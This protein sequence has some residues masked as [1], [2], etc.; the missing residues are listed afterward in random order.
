MWDFYITL[1]LPGEGVPPVSVLPLFDWCRECA[2]SLCKCLCVCWIR[3]S[4]IYRGHLGIR[5]VFVF[6][7]LLLLNW[8]TKILTRSIFVR[9]HT[10]A[11]QCY[12]VRWLQ[13]CCRHQQPTFP[14]NGSV[15]HHH[16]KRC[17]AAL[18][19]M[20]AWFSVL[21]FK[22]D[23]MVLSYLL[24][25]SH[26]PNKGP[27]IGYPIFTWPARFRKAKDFLC[28]QKSV[29]RDARAIFGVFY[30]RLFILLSSDLQ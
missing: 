16:G 26:S 19:L 8:P 30:D 20:C 22:I 15:K 6:A 4:Y 18:L 2:T 9:G 11:L 24:I 13:H 23:I 5:N 21:T 12:M 3:I 29:L 27:D 10:Y 17:T 14:G 25:H 28:K 7:D 1:S